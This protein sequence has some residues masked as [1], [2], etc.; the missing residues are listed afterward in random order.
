MAGVRGGVDDCLFE[1]KGLPEDIA[2][3]AENDNFLYISDTKCSCG[4]SRSVTMEN[5]ER[6]VKGESSVFK[7]NHEGKPTWVSGPDWHSHSWLSLTEY[8]Q[9]LEKYKVL[10]Q[11]DFEIRQEENLDFIKYIKENNPD[12]EIKEDSWLMAPIEH[13]DEPEYHAIE[14]AMNR[15]EEMGYE[16]RLVFWFDN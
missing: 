15:L 4:E 11:K 1:P 2:Y 12:V 13:Y 6:W 5:A 16:S 9:V 10:E 3:A 8:K 14:A 7:N